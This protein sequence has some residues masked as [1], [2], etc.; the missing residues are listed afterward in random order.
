MNNERTTSRKT[1]LSIIGLTGWYGALPL[2]SSLPLSA[3]EEQ[4]R[5]LFSE[6]SVGDWLAHTCLLLSLAIMVWHSR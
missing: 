1:G 5:I 6:L 2:L 4:S 3:K